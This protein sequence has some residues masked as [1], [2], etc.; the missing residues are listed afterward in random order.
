[1]RGA[2]S[3]SLQLSVRLPLFQ[4][5]LLMRGATV[6]ARPIEPQKRAISIHAPHARSDVRAIFCARPAEI[7]I[8][9]PHA[10]SDRPRRPRQH[11]DENFNPRSSCEERPQSTRVISRAAFDFNPRSSCEERHGLKYG[12]QGMPEFQSTLLMRGATCSRA[13]RAR[14]L[15]S[16]QSTLLMRGATSAYSE[17][18]FAGIFQS[19]LLM[20][21][22]TASAIGG[23]CALAVFQST[24]LMRGATDHIQAGRRGRCISIHA[25]HARS[26]H[27]H[28]VLLRHLWHFNP[29]SSC[30]ERHEVRRRLLHDVQFQ[31]TLLMRGA[32]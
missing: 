5:T 24:L 31:S 20:R 2:T 14:A 29:R 10:R 27:G 30:E 32:T 9:A 26:D 19:T 23:A 11:A 16:F 25:P 22:A 1:M 15:R 28:S 6:R 12:L 17:K 3:L 13:R 7:S 4:S 18:N 8:H 21:G